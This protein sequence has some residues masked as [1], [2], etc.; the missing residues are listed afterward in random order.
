[1][2]AEDTLITDSLKGW[3]FLYNRGFIEGFG[4]L[5]ARLP[6]SDRFLITRHSMGARGN[7]D[8]LLTVD[9]KGRKLA[10]KGELPGEYPIHLEI[11]K[12][13]PDVNCVI[14][15][16][17]MYSTSFTTSEHTLKPIHLMGALFHTG[18]P[19]YPDPR[20]VHA[21]P[22]GAALARALGPHRAVLMKAHGVAVTGANLLEAVGG[23]FFFEQNAHRAWISAS[24]GKPQWL[25]EQTIAACAS[26]LYPYRRVW[27]MV[28]ADAAE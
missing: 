13:R 2:S 24:I 28:E 5:S 16:H 1:M 25:D 4:H 10:G 23:A 15:Y 22:R 8:D 20:L 14:H 18:I 6:D 17:G 12:A 21:A 7:P 19:V 9:I 27:A 26:E 3:R 11:Y